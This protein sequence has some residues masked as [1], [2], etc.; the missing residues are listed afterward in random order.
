MVASVAQ[1]QAARWPLLASLAIVII[2]IRQFYGSSSSGQLVQGPGG[3]F[4]GEDGGGA[5]M[6]TKYVADAASVGD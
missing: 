4:H 1:L 5:E 3:S 2:V 6:V